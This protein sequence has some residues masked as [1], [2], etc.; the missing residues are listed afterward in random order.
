MRD[1][2]PT[3]VRLAH[4][5]LHPEPRLI[6]GLLAPDAA[7]LRAGVAVDHALT[8]AENR[9][10]RKGR[11]QRRGGTRTGSYASAETVTRAGGR[12]TIA[13]RLAPYCRPYIT[14]PATGIRAVRI[15]PCSESVM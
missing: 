12:L 11:V 13:A 3:R 15:S 6:L 8:L 10:E 9:H 5:Q 14:L 4:R 7:H 2:P 1:A